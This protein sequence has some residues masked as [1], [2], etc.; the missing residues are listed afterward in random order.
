MSRQIPPEAVTETIRRLAGRLGRTPT[1][2]EVIREGVTWRAVANHFGTYNCAVEVA[3]LRPNR[4]LRPYRR[5]TREG[6]VAAVRELSVMLGR[7]PTTGDLRAHPDI[8]P[9]PALVLRRFGSIR[10]LLREAGLSPNG[11]G[12]NRRRRREDRRGGGVGSPGAAPV[13]CE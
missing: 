2:G 3:G 10:N 1:F 7:T 9:P 12:S 6:M 8:C 5:W 11:P 4:V 13:S